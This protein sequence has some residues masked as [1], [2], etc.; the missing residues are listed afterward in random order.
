MM[1]RATPLLLVFLLVSLL[2]ACGGAEPSIPVTGQ[3]SDL[4]L[5]VESPN[6]ESAF[7]QGDQAITYNYVV[8]NTGPQALPGPVIVND[9]PRQVSCPQLNTVGNL[10]DKLDFNESVT[11]T[12]FYTP[13]ESDRNAGSIT[14]RAQAIVG[15]AVSTESTFTLGQ[16]AATPTGEG[17]G[18]LDGRAASP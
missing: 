11:C 13:S 1:N 15:G 4:Q 2:A 12:A 7:P 6:G 10:D 8:S 18:Q 5:E 3:R 16:A 9:A 17:S 14:N